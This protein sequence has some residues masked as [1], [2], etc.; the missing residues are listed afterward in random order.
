MKSVWPKYVFSN[1]HT[2]IDLYMSTFSFSSSAVLTIRNVSKS[3]KPTDSCMNTNIKKNIILQLHYLNSSFLCS[4]LL[5]FAL[6]ELIV[7]NNIT[8]QSINLQNYEKK[9]IIVELMLVTAS[10]ILVANNS[11]YSNHSSHN[12]CVWCGHFS[13]FHR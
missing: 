7:F 6:N 8:Y 13:H 3:L 2:T 4:D 1:Y 5:Y 9:N 12:F 11:L 10:D